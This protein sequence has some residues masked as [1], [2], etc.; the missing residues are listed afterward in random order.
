MGEGNRASGSPSMRWGDVRCPATVFFLQSWGLQ[1]DLLL[2]SFQNSCLAAC[3]VISSLWLYLAKEIRKRWKFSILPKTQ[4][5]FSV[6]L[7]SYFSPPTP[8]NSLLRHDSL[9]KCIHVRCTVQWFFNIVASLSNQHCHWIPEHLHPPRKKLYIHRLSLALILLFPVP[10]HLLSIHRD[11][12]SLGISHKWNYTICS[13]SLTHV[14]G[15]MVLHSFHVQ[16]IFYLINRPHFDYPFISWISCFHFRVLRD[17]AAE[18]IHRRAC[19][20]M[21]FHFSWVYA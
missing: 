12:P 19:V 6:F 5:P 15:G 14:R 11:L 4:A 8:L 16:I 21:Y 13:S 3:C 7:T 9:M 1:A 2:T 18:N 17:H 20:D 10:W